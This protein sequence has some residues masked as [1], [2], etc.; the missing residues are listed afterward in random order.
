MK[1]IP[2]KVSIPGYPYYI[3]I[4]GEVFREGSK[5]PLKP[6]NSTYGIYVC[7][8]KEGRPVKFRVNNLMKNA[9]FGGGD[10]LMKHKDGDKWNFRYSNLKPIKRNQISTF[11]RPNSWNAKAV[12]ET[13][14]DG[15]E[16]IYA[17]AAECARKLFVSKSTVRKW[18]LGVNG[19]TVNG[20]KYRYEVQQ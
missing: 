20:N 17:S 3:T 1:Q 14:P 19:N 18:C 6:I 4:D 5:K 11:E 16:N 8:Y 10:F 9:Y 2:Q 13:L 7:L 12:I 15:T